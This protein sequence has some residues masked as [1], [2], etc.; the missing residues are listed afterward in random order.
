MTPRCIKCNCFK[1]INPV[2]QQYRCVECDLDRSYGKGYRHGRKDA[3]KRIQPADLVA[4]A[5][6][7]L[8]MLT[9]FGTLAWAIGS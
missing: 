8:S 7:V 1:W 3:R 2:T 5:A 4:Y 6:L 9:V